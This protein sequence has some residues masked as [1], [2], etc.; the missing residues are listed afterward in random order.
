M[1]IYWLKADKLWMKSSGVSMW[2]EPVQKILNINKYQCKNKIV[3]K[4]QLI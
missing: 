1:W 4:K 2:D 3:S